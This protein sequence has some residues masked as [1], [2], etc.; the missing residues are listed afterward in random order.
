MYEKVLAN[1]EEI[2]ARGGPVIAV[3]D[4]DDSQVVDLADDR[5]RR[6]DSRRLLAADRRERA[7][8]A[9]GLPHRLGARLRR[10]QTSQSGQER[11]RGIAER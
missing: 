9:L 8:A 4:D 2:K 1:V 10:R 5:D 7:P 11:D 6:A 3:V